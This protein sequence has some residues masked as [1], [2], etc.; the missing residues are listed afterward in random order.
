[1]E[2]FEGKETIVCPHC[3]H[4]F[5]PDFNFICNKCRTPLCDLCDKCSNS[6]NE[7]KNKDDQNKDINGMCNFKSSGF[8]ETDLDES[9]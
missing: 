5:K 1:M 2:K 8:Y 4:M 6:C 3:W 7:R 9:L